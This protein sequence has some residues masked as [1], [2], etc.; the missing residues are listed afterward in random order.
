MTSITVGQIDRF[1]SDSLHTPL[2]WVIVEG[3]KILV[4]LS[5]VPD[6]TLTDHVLIAGRHAVA[7]VEP[8]VGETHPHVY[9]QSHHLGT[10]IDLMSHPL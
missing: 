2:A 4:D 7:L 10:L 6:A 1:A 3:Q 8:A 9:E 5:Y